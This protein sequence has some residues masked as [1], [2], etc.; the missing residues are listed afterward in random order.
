MKIFKKIVSLLGLMLIFLF[1]NLT[2]QDFS[3][4]KIEPPNWWTNLTPDTVQLMIYGKNLRGVQVKGEDKNF[5][6]VA[7]KEAFSQDYLFVY[8][9][10]KRRKAGS[11]ALK[12]K[13][14]N[15]ELVRHYSI[16]ERNRSANAR[17]GFNENDV[18]YLIFADR[19]CDG[20]YSN[21][22]IKNPFEQFKPMTLNGRHGGDLQGIIDK[23]DYLKDLG[24]TAL[25]ITPV[26]ENNMWMSYHGYAAT[27]LY[28]VDSRF[29]TN[30]LY[31]ELV[32]KAHGKG[33][34]IIMDHVSNHIGI[35]S[36]WVKDLPAKD[37]F[38]G[39]PGSFPKASNNKIAYFDVHADSLTPLK[40]QRGWFTDYMPDL[41][42]S[43]K[44]LADYMIENTIWWIEYL[45]IDGIR[46][47]T[48]PYNNLNYMSKWAS[49]IKKNFPRF[50]IVAE[51]WKGL[52]AFLAEYQAN[53]VIERGFNSYV[54][55]VT[56]YALYDA[57][58]KFLEGKVDGL[59]AI[60][61][62]LAQDFLYRHPEKLMTFIGNHDVDR[63]LSVAG[64]DV[65]RFKCALGLLLTT[66]GI[67]QLFYGDE[68]GLEGEGHDGKIRKHFP[69]GF[70]G[71]SR[72]AFSF[73]GRTERENGIFNFVKRLLQIRKTYP[74]LRRGKLIHF[75]PEKQVYVYFRILNSQKLM[76]VI[77]G[78]R[79]DGKLSLK[80]ESYLLKSTKIKNLFTGEQFKYSKE[81]KLTAPAESFQIFLV[82]EK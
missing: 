30:E 17:R 35:N 52:P 65:K 71:D 24:V 48:Y 29:G 81:F 73:D 44:L 37:W 11:Y 42:K 40:T 32:R 38:H 57:I 4:N 20:D 13:K 18:I 69:G 53:P 26:L 79:N 54:Q 9:N 67:P 58:R 49:E 70:P 74:A 3:I 25:W 22:S 16:K 75:P 78:G 55:S 1:K 2:G 41:N 8:F 15:N 61:E 23:L 12:F 21:D 34:K 50:S 82:E 56:D 28:K 72:N 63:A 7:V 59:N 39:A 10:L 19:F 51:V 14:G 46:E 64:G 66:R 62:T 5:R 6:I 68:I 80:D 33:L 47:D 45:G 76:I 27:N 43:N 77:N 60:Y 31:R 36:P